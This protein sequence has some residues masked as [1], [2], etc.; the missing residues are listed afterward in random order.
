MKEHCLKKKK[1]RRKI[2]IYFWWTWTELTHA[3]LL[4][5]NLLIGK[6]KNWTKHVYA[7]QI[8]KAQE[9][10]WGSACKWVGV[11]LFLATRAAALSSVLCMCGPQWPDCICCF[12]EGR[13]RAPVGVWGEEAR[14]HWKVTCSCCHCHSEIQ[15]FCDLLFFHKRKARSDPNNHSFLWDWKERWLYHLMV[16]WARC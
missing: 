8:T 15:T 13:V 5:I 7:N 14:R 12:K 11:R 10:I 16:M 6:C 1:E 9:A 3:V 2:K 4:R